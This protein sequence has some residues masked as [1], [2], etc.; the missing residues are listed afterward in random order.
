MACD[1]CNAQVLWLADNYISDIGGLSTLVG[2]KQLNLARND[3][4]SI[5]SGLDSST[6]LT[7]LNLAGNRIDNFQVSE[8]ASRAQ[9]NRW[10][11]SMSEAR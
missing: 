9:P 8:E 10:L 3:I 2:L 5:G 11:T 6:G 4:Q 7:Y 1:C